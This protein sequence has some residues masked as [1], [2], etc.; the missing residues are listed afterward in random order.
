MRAIDQR[1]QGLTGLLGQHRVKMTMQGTLDLRREHIKQA[2]QARQ[3]HKWAGQQ[4]RPDMQAPEH[5][6][7]AGGMV[8]NR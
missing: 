3:H 4:G 2:S 1:V 5:G 6:A 7:A 8:A